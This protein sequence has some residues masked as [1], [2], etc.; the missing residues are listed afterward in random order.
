[1]NCLLPEIQKRLDDHDEESRTSVKK[2]QELDA[3]SWT[4]AQRRDKD[5]LAIARF[6]IGA[7]LGASHLPPTVITLDIHGEVS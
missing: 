7:L 5:K 1:M 4:I 6:I 2:P 3:I